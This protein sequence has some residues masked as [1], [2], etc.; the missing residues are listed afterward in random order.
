MLLRIET[1]EDMITTATL[2]ALPIKYDQIFRLRVR[3]KLLIQKL[4]QGTLIFCSVW[5][6]LLDK[7]GQNQK[8]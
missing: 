7:S 5:R 6:P 2:M 4:L 3:E 1:A 8:L